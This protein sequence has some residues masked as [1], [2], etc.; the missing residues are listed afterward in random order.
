[1]I[2]LMRQ[3]HSSVT[4]CRKWEKINKGW[5]LSK[6]CMFIRI[7]LHNIEIP[8]LNFNENIEK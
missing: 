6:N 7:F 8:P 1:M 3:M 4:L 5:G 2:D